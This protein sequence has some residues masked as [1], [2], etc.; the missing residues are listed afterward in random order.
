MEITDLRYVKEEQIDLEER[1]KNLKKMQTKMVKRT[2]KHFSS[3]LKK[4]KFRNIEFY[5][6]ISR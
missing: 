3:P 1:L 4:Q 5:E 6:D 2:K